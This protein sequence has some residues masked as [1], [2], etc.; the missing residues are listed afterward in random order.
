[1]NTN[2]HTNTGA[3]DHIMSELDK[4]ST[5]EKYTGQEKIQTTN[6]SGMR[7]SYVDNSTLQTPTRNLHLY[8][9]LHVPST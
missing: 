7:I 5:K 2:W 4:L 1:V 6:G 8:H 3:A 9:I